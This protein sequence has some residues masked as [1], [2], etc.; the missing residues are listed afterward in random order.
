MKSYSETEG[1]FTPEMLQYF[2]HAQQIVKY[3]PDMIEGARVRCHEV[4]RAVHLCLEQ[5][6]SVWANS[7]YKYKL[8]C[9]ILDGKVGPM[10]HSFILLAET[11]DKEPRKAILDPYCVGRL[12][13]VQLVNIANH[14]ELYKP[15]PMMTDG[16]NFRHLEIMSKVLTPHGL[17]FRVD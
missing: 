3:L 6:P 2:E 7:A 8:K 15:G 10:P 4:A 13:Q 16:I 12:P 11:K 5:R 14:L 9:T 17:G 1:V